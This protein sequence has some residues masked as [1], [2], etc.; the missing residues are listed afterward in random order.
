M[1]WHDRL[2][3]WKRKYGC[4]ALPPLET[5]EI[6]SAAVR[7]GGIPA[8]LRN[9]YEQCNGLS[10]E[11]FRVLP[12]ESQRDVK[13]T[14]N[15]ISRANDPLTTSFLGADRELLRRFL[16]FASL[17][18]G[19]CAVIDRTDESIWFEEADELS[20][21]DLDLAGFIEY[22]LKEVMELG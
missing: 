8:Q 15:G 18:A 17:D 21:T 1:N 9:F 20:Q 5:S 2:D 16:V 12:I 13:R 6:E 19:R 10:C 22:C 11:W 14:W 3:S 7:I 4:R